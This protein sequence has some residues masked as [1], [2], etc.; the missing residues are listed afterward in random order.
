MLPRIVI[1][2]ILSMV[3]LAGCQSSQPTATTTPVQQITTLSGTVA[4]FLVTE[5]PRVIVLEQ[6]Q[7]GFSRIVLDENAAGELNTRTVSKDNCPLAGPPLQKSDMIEVTGRVDV[8]SGNFIA[9]E[10]KVVSLE[11]KCQP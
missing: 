6:P 10:I 9:E 3:L 7:Q 2:T 4:D 1:I 11:A 8:K 5:R